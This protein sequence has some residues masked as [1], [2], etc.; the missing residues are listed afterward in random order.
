MAERGIP[1]EQVLMITFTKA[2]AEEMKMKFKRLGGP[3]GV[4]F[5]TIHAL[6][7]KILLTFGGYTGA[8]IMKEAD[9]RFL[10]VNLAKRD[11]RINDPEKAVS[12]FMTQYSVARNNGIE[13]TEVNPEGISRESFIYLANRYEDFKVQEHKIDFDDMLMKAY[14]LLKERKDILSMLQ[15]KWR[16]IQV[17]EYQDTN[18]LQKNI[19]YLLAGKYNN[20][21]VAGDDDQSIYRFRGA[22]P[23]IM[24]N[25]LHDF[26]NA[27][28]IN[29]STNYRSCPQII[30]YAGNLIRHNKVRLDKQFLAGCSGDASITFASAKNS[31]EEISQMIREIGQSAYDPKDIAV[32]YRNNRQ[33]EAVASLF[34]KNNI[35]FVSTEKI[36]DSYESWIWEDIM[37]YYRLS[38][39]CGSRKDF[40][41]ILDRPNRY[42][43]RI[44]KNASGSDKQS[45][46]KEIAKISQSWQREK[47]QESVNRLFSD[48]D[49][50]E[51]KEPSGFLMY[52]FTRMGY[53]AYLKQYSVSV[54]QDFG[55]I[56][57]ALKIYREDAKRF[58]NMED[59]MTYIRRRS[60]LLKQS[61]KDGITLSTM[62]RSKGLEWKC[63][64]IIDCNEDVIPSKNEK[65]VQ[66]LEEERRLFYVAVTRAKDCLHLLYI[67]NPALQKE[68]SRFLREMKNASEENN[69]D[70]GLRKNDMVL[71]KALG[72]CMIMEPQ[73]NSCRI[74]SLSTGKEHCVPKCL[75]RK[76]AV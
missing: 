40:A 44:Y 38:R 15:E 62:H 12:I 23:E 54:N 30:E 45:L 75:L 67:K 58:T 42:L 26:P 65:S 5:S 68:P 60:F 74:R 18:G 31:E 7:L 14:E 61:Q 28:K 59:W 43:S 29:I 55:S 25:F 6:C 39:K 56:E 2:A 22:N 21:C 17:D 63:V 36:L 57:S 37:A 71:H 8:D 72:I 73:G 20:L 64:Y 13:I 27:K 24:Q 49:I 46:L 34:L 51:T 52:L 69:A 70:S 10:L 48:L 19:I 32:L 11:C 76:T 66:A 50:L 41:R 3:V 1:P 33:A 35:P 47:A 16:Y 53:L 4:T 9:A